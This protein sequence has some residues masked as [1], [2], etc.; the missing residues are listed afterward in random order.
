MA[1]LS[2]WCLAS[3]RTPTALLRIG[4][5]LGI[6]NAKNTLDTRRGLKTPI[7][8]KISNSN[9]EWK[10]TCQ[11]RGFRT[12]AS[13]PPQFMSVRVT[14]L[15]TTTDYRPGAGMAQIEKLL[16]IPPPETDVLRGDEAPPTVVTQRA[17]LPQAS[18]QK[19]VLPDNRSWLH[20]GSSDGTVKAATWQKPTSADVDATLKSVEKRMA[21]DVPRLPV[22]ASELH[23]NALMNQHD[24]LDPRHDGLAIDLFGEEGAADYGLAA[25][26][27]AYTAINSGLFERLEELPIAPASVDAAHPSDPMGTGWDTDSYSNA[28]DMAP[29][30]QRY[31]DA[32]DRFVDED[33]EIE[34][35]DA[36]LNSYSDEKATADGDIPP[37]PP[38]PMPAPET[39][40]TTVSP[41]SPSS[42]V[43]KAK[44]LFIA[45]T[46]EDVMAELRQALSQRQARQASVESTVSSAASP[47]PSSATSPSPLRVAAGLVKGFE[48]MTDTHK[49]SLSG[50]SSD[51]GRGSHLLDAGADSDHGWSDS[52]A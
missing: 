42:P 19:N 33:R 38:P 2:L 5:A 49:E 28:G 46:R 22:R 45:P 6:Q 3:M 1:V 24:F 32:T 21:P 29:I 17:T 48:L 18:L 36:M 47:S 41:L 4:A 13:M 35:F 37:P 15:R 39:S 23:P 44:A 30:G 27:I 26:D 20:P 34:A 43:S 25:F 52:E 50:Y 31:P 12:V 40:S 9:K 11:Q 16:C 10:E 7:L 8:T 51:S 14:P